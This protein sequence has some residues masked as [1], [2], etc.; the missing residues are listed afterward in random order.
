MPCIGAPRFLLRS[1]LRP[2]GG[3]LQ[4]PGVFACPPHAPRLREAVRDGFDQGLI[5]EGVAAPGGG[6]RMSDAKRP[7][8]R[9]NLDEAVERAFGRGDAAL[10]T[11]T[12]LADVI[13]AQMLP[14]GVVKGVSG[15]S[16]ARRSARSRFSR[17]G[18]PHGPRARASRLAGI[19]ERVSGCV[20]SCRLGGREDAL[21]LREFCDCPRV[22]RFLHVAVA[23][24]YQANA[25]FNLAE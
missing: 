19:G 20:E 14:D 24:Q 5:K 13:V 12:V 2:R 16:R 8:R 6:D 11:R 18:R 15:S 3:I 22:V 25:T 10:R 17:S 7:N 4:V 21:Q 23:G 9:I 1:W